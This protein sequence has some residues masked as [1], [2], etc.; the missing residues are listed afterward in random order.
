MKLQLDRIGAM[1]DTI[2]GIKFWPGKNY[3]DY[4]RLKKRVDERM[5]LKRIVKIELLGITTKFQKMVQENLL[6]LK[7]AQ[8]IL[9]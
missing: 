6:L 8:N 5:A 3:E 1:N 7:Q 4:L 9:D 2:R